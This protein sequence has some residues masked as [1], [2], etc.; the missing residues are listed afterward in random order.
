M[1]DDQP[2]ASIQPRQWAMFLHLSLLAGFIIP[3]AGLAVPIII[4]QMKKGD[5]PEIDAHGKIVVNWMISSLIYWAIGFILTF[6]LIGIPILM[7]L[8]VLAVVF[9]II[10]GIKANNGEVWKYP[11]SITFLK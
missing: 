8:V 7:V 10:A 6:V 11:L 2:K 3:V 1:N 4:W 9:P 5:I